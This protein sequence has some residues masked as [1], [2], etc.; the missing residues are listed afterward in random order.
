MGLRFHVTNGNRMKEMFFFL[1]FFL[2]LLLFLK[3]WMPTYLSY[4]TVATEEGKKTLKSTQKRNVYQ[5]NNIFKT[6]AQPCNFL[7]HHQF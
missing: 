1:I 7:K 4:K 6:A 3:S 2:F 5:N